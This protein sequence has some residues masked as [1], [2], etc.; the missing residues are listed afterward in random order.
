MRPPMRRQRTSGKNDVVYATIVDAGQIQS[1][2]TG[3]FPTT[4]AK[5][6]KYVLV[7]FDNDTNNIPTEPMKNRGDKEMVRA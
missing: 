2:L 6:N 3:L 1:D 7:L 5:G 4:S